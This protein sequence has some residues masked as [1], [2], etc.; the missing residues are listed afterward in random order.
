MLLLVAVISHIAVDAGYVLVVPIGGIMFYVAG[1][2]PAG[3]HRRGVCRAS[4]ADSARTFIPSAIDPMLAKITQSGVELVA[5]DQSVNP[6]CNIFFMASSTGLIVLMGWFL[7]DVVVEPR[8]AGNGA[9]RRRQRDAADSKPN[10][11]ASR[12]PCSAGWA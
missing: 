9:G 2:T 1:Q 8:L 11:D 5:A 4:P 7:T 3:R 10:R 6:L 12:S